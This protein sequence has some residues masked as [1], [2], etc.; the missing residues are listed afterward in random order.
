MKHSVSFAAVMALAVLLVGCTQAP[1]ELKVAILLP[2]PARRRPS[3][4]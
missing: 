3:A 2:S 4:S 1:K